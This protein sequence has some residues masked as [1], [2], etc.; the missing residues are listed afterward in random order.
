M[1]H[2]KVVDY[3]SRQL[4]VHEKNYPNHDLELAAVVF[5]L[6]IWRHY[7]YVVHGDVYTDHS[8][9]QY[10]FTQKKVSDK[11]GGWNSCRIT[12]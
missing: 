4:Q 7:L 5:A 6:R 10:G 11:E 12:T 1:K 2:A 3:A 9:H 8:S